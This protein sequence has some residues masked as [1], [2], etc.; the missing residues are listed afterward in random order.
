MELLKNESLS[1]CPKFNPVPVHKRVKHTEKFDENAPNS[2]FLH[3]I[4]LENRTYVYFFE[5]SHLVL[6]SLSLICR[7]P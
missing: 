1:P 6:V 3:S 5:H 7:D 4:L 2:I